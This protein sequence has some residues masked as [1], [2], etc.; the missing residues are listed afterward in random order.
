M[1]L[2][3]KIVL[4]ACLIVGFFLNAQETPPPPGGIENKGVGPG[5]PASPIDM[6]V[7]VLL[8]FAMILIYYTAKKR[9][10]AI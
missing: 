1:K 9:K 2:L 8:I 10:V 5:A 3:N 6:Y 7:Y 4:F